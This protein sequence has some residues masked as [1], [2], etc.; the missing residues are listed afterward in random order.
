MPE[1]TNNLGLYKP[2]RLDDVEIDTSLATNFETIDSKLGSALTKDGV[3]YPDLNARLAAEQAS[4]DNDLEGQIDNLGSRLDEI[5]R[6]Q[7]NTSPVQFATLELAHTTVLQCFVVNEKTNQIFATQVYDS[8]APQS[9]IISRM[10]MD[11]T[12]IDKMTLVHGGHGTA[13]GIENRGDQVYIWSQ[14]ERI[15]DAGEAV[16]NDLVCFPYTPNAN[17]NEDANTITRYNN[18]AKDS[19][20]VPVIDQKNNRMAIRQKVGSP[21]PTPNKITIHD[22]NKVKSNVNEPLYTFEIPKEYYY[23]Q[24]FSLDGN[25]LYWYMGDTNE[26]NHPIQIVVF[27]IRDGSIVQIKKIGVN[28]TFSSMYE[29]DFREPEGVYMY[30]DPRTG[31]KSLMVGITSGITGARISKIYAYHSTENFAL[32]TPYIKQPMIRQDQ[33]GGSSADRYRPFMISFQL[34]YTS[35][36][37]QIVPSGQDPNYWD[38]VIESISIDGNDLLVRMRER[39]MGLVYQSISPDW[40]CAINNILVG[41]NYYAGGADSRDVRI[42]F[43]KNGT[44]LAPNNAAIPSGARLG[45]LLIANEKIE[46]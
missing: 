38:S 13:F 21:D 34:Q 31:S 20:L 15:N 5:E 24:G 33:V 12:L 43:G 28:T 6:F 16:G 41:S 46:E 1:Y 8:N 14:F 45:V 11:G 7:F 4:N 23:F 3:T 18:V 29:G 19:T 10:N 42:R 26:A 36:A 44:Q 25:Y 2:N 27:D 17:W 22:L 35:G 39:Y 32:H 9:F 30:T 37:W 40:Y